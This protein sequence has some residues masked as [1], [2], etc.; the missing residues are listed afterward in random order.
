MCIN[1][2]VRMEDIHE[3]NIPYLEPKDSEWLGMNPDKKFFQ[4][5]SVKPYNEVHFSL[6]GPI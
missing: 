5:T 1:K 4:A 6:K 2:Y 3:D